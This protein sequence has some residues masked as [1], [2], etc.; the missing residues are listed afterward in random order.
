M[1]YI[2]ENEILIGIDGID[3]RRLLHSEIFYMLDQKCANIGPYKKDK[4][5]TSLQLRIALK[6]KGFTLEEDNAELENER[7]E[8]T[9]ADNDN[10]KDINLNLVMKLKK[11]FKK[12]KLGKIKKGQYDIKLSNT[13]GL[14]L[15]GAY[16]DNDGDGMGDLNADEMVGSLVYHKDGMTDKKSRKM[17]SI[18]DRVVGVDDMDLYDADHHEIDYMVFEKL[19]RGKRTIRF[20]KFVLAKLGPIKKDELDV[21]L[22]Y[23]DVMHIPWTGKTDFDACIKSELT[24]DNPARM[25]G[26]GKGDRL[27][28]GGGMNVTTLP[29]NGVL[30]YL[31]QVES[32][33]DVHILRFKNLPKDYWTR[34][35][36]NDG[37]P[38]FKDTE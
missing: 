29:F 21:E 36:D 8:T 18:G 27:I 34:D 37:I 19:K 17:L 1:P 33:H 9:S 3:I 6:E 26:V 20:E 7:S 2:Q 14:E 22:K 25:A 24:A 5:K 23:N 13:S 16:L 30:K 15:C 28:G 10:K 32:D 12:G 11:K 35:T 4:K 38:D 31:K